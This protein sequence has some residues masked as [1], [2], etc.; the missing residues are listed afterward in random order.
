LLPT[1]QSDTVSTPKNHSLITSGVVSA[2]HTSSAGASIVIELVDR[3]SLI[4]R[5]LRLLV[6]PQF[7]SP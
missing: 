7:C 5:H 3:I 1:F 4:E 2:S 6:G